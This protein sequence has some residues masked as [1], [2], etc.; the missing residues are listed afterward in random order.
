MKTFLLNYIFS[1]EYEYYSDFLRVVQ[2]WY[3]AENMEDLVRILENDIYLTFLTQLN[4]D[5]KDSYHQTIITLK[6]KK[7]ITI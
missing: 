5:Y 7:N 6:T 1:P 4:L 3:S 2:M